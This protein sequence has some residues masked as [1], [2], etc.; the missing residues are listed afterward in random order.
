MYSS[1][2]PSKLKTS[3]CETQKNSDGPAKPN[4]QKGRAPDQPTGDRRTWDL[5]STLK[6]WKL[7]PHRK[8]N[9]ENEATEPSDKKQLE[10][11]EPQRSRRMKREG[12]C[13]LQPAFKSR[14]NQEPALSTW[15]S[16]NQGEEE[17]T[18]TGR[19]APNNVH[20]SPLT[21]SFR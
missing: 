13:S 10:T 18:T 1:Y 11:P 2:S 4:R 7:N 16:R 21:I 12:G 19:G 8:E 9:R 6:G 20:K 5:P 17:S 3:S 14:P 15:R